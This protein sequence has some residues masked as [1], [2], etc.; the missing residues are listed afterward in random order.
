MIWLYKRK[1]WV[2]SHSGLIG[3][4]IEKLIALCWI[5]R[6]EQLVNRGHKEL[7][8]KKSNK[9]NCLWSGD[10]PLKGGIAVISY[11]FSISS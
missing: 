4:V 7:E 8:K 6:I 5:W 11:S 3:K 1:E 10:K 2:V 9:I